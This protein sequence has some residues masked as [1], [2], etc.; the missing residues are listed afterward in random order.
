MPSAGHRGRPADYR[1]GGPLELQTV[2]PRWWLSIGRSSIHTTGD[3]SNGDPLHPVLTYPIGDVTGVD[4]LML[5][6]Y[7]DD[8]ANDRL[9]RGRG[10]G[11]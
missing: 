11:G 8:L 10:R 5:E 4:Q 6:R 1:C 9:G 3:I 7:L 2:R